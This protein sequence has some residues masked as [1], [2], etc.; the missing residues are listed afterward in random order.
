MCKWGTTKILNIN[1]KDRSIDSCIFDLVKALN[2]GGCKTVACC[3]GHGR[4]QGDI[5]LAD[6][7][8]LIIM[9]N[10]NSSRK[11]DLLLK[12]NYKKLCL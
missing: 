9:P 10:F 1:G 2:D 3:C 8:E 6:G 11:L 4:S 7:R 12:D 5:A